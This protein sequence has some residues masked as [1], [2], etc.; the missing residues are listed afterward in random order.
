LSEIGRKNVEILGEVMAKRLIPIVEEIK[1]IDRRRGYA[2][3]SN[4]CGYGEK[5]IQKVV[6][7]EI[8]VRR[9]DDQPQYLED[10]D[11]EIIIVKEPFHQ[12]L[13]RE[14]LKQLFKK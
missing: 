7:E 8:I 1:T 5:I 12:Q 2:K 9:E 14:L 6:S 10:E 4:I 11:V 13:E 3:Y